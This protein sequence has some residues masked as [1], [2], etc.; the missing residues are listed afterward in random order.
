MKANAMAIENAVLATVIAKADDEE[1]GNVA[2]MAIEALA[3][4]NAEKVDAEKA[5]VLETE[6]DHRAKVAIVV[7]ADQSWTHWTETGMVFWSLTKLIR[8]S[9]CCDG[10]TAIAMEK[11]LPMNLVDVVLDKVIGRREIDLSEKV[12]VVEARADHRRKK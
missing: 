3:V 7:L 5:T 6:S 2:E 9:S 8:R 10:W 12:R 1:T 4:V 11:S